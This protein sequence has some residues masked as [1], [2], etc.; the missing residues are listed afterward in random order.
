MATI[1]KRCCPSC[2]QLKWNHTVSQN[3][4]Y[5][6]TVL[7]IY[8][9]NLSPQTSRKSAHSL[10]VRASYV[11]CFMISKSAEVL[12]F[13]L[14]RC[15]QYRVILY[16]DISRVYSTTTHQ[17]NQ[18]IRAETKCPPSCRRLFKIICLKRIIQFRL[19]SHCCVDP[20]CIID[21]MPTCIGFDDVLAP[22]GR[23]TITWTNDGLLYEYICDSALA[24]QR[25]IFR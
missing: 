21:N 22:N 3:D 13:S 5:H 14:L 16:R 2:N 7:S 4:G 8:R 1:C 6:C 12:P 10:P 9:G 23:Q 24:N 20:I 15:V 19:V 18:H 25:N 17:E 11:V